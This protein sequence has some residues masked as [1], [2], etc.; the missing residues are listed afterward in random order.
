M[1]FRVIH[2]DV[3][4]A[5]VTPFGGTVAHGYLTLSPMAPI[6]GGVPDPAVRL[7]RRQG[8]SRRI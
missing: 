6:S 1:A 2:V 7:R 5:K 4:R 8:S 3:E